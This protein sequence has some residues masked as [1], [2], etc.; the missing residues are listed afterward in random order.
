MTFLRSIVTLLAV[1][2]CIGVAYAVGHGLSS[3]NSMA[4]VV[5]LVMLLVG[6]GMVAGLARQQRQ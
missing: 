6:A 3:H 5:G 2:L 4:F 1:C